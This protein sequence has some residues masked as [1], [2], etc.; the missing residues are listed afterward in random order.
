M[1]K[2]ILNALVAGALKEDEA[3]QVKGGYG[4]HKLKI[5]KGLIDSLEPEQISH[6]AKL[7]LDLEKCVSDYRV[8]NVYKK[9][10]FISSLN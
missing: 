5:P 7:Q 3:P 1:G 10:Q 8:M 4:N 2:N 9:S 6:L